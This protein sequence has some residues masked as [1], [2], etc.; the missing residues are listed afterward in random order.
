MKKKQGRHHESHHDGDIENMTDTTPPMETPP[1][2]FSAE[3]LPWWSAGA[4]WTTGILGVGGVVGYRA[5]MKENADGAVNK[6]MENAWG[7]S[8]G[9]GGGGGGGAGGGAAKPHPFFKPP[10]GSKAAAMPPT[11]VHFAARTLGIATA[12]CVGTCA[13]LGTGLALAAGV[14]SPSDARRK[15]DEWKAW[16]PDFRRRCLEAV[17]VR[18]SEA[19]RAAEAEL[20]DVAGLS[21]ERQLAVLVE[22]YDKS[23]PANGSSGGGGGVGATKK[24]AAADPAV[25]AV[26]LHTKQEEVAPPTS[27]PSTTISSSSSRTE[28]PA[29]ARWWSFWR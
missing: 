12:L 3:E 17:G 8:G 9:S 23:V 26:A 6:V 2:W 22:K 27:V 25:A 5:S 18:E 19:S 15:V 7:G 11:T 1:S 10:P 4:V 28:K 20:R 29:S 16:A 13:A 21:P 14:R 24:T